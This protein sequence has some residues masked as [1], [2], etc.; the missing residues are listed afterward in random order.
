MWLTRGMISPFMLLTG[1]R[2]IHLNFLAESVTSW[3]IIIITATSQYKGSCVWISMKTPSS[4]SDVVQRVRIQTRTC[5]LSHRTSGSPKR[6]GIHH[7]YDYLVSADLQSLQRYE[8][9]ASTLCDLGSSGGHTE[10]GS[11]CSHVG[12]SG[13][14]IVNSGPSAWRGAPAMS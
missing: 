13:W 8:Q 12:C 4:N 2:P 11:A 3:C 14:L 1:P 9:Q 6:L 5:S 7:S 10:T